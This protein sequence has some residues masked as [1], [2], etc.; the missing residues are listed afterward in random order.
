M[1]IQ[2]RLDLLQTTTLFWAMGFPF[3]FPA[4]QNEAEL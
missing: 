2:N 1:N 4:A 3:I